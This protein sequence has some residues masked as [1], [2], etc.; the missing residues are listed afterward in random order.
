MSSQKTPLSASKRAV[1]IKISILHTSDRDNFPYTSVE[2]RWSF[3]MNLLP[4]TNI[5]EL[6]I[7]ATSQVQRTF[8][9]IQEAARLEARDRDGHVFHGMET[10]AEEIL[11]GETIYLVEG[12]GEG[13]GRGKGKERGRLLSLR[14]GAEQAYRTPST[15]SRSSSTSR[16]KAQSQP[17]MTPSQRSR[18][19]AKAGLPPGYEPARVRRSSTGAIGRTNSPSPESSHVAPAAALKGEV[20]NRRDDASNA[21]DGEPAI[22]KQETSIAQSQKRSPSPHTSPHLQDSQKLIPD[23]QNN[24][25]PR[26][27]LQSHSGSRVKLASETKLRLG[28]SELRPTQPRSAPPRLNTLDPGNIHNMPTPPTKVL[29]SRPDPYDISSVLSDNEN[30]S[31]TR[32]SSIMSSSVRKLG[33]AYKRRIPASQPPMRQLQLTANSPS[34]TSKSATADRYDATRNMGFQHLT[35][36]DKKT[37]T[38]F[39]VEASSPA[40]ALPSSPTNNVAAAIAKGRSKIQRRSIPECVVISDSEDDIDEELFRNPPAMP[41]SIPSVEASLPWSQ[42]PLW[43]TQDKVLGVRPVAHRASMPSAGGRITQKKVVGKE[44]VVDSTADVRRLV[45][46]V[47]GTLTATSVNSN[48]RS[49]AL[50]SSAISSFGQPVTVIDSLSS[51]N[52]SDGVD[53]CAPIIKAEQ[54]EDDVWKDLPDAIMSDSP[55]HQDGGDKG[56]YPEV[57]QLSSDSD[58]SIDPAWLDDYDVDLPISELP[59]I[60]APPVINEP[61]LPDPDPQDIELP[62]PVVPLQ[63]LNSLV[64]DPVEPSVNQTPPSAQPDKRKR[65]LVGDSDSENEREKKRVKKAEKRR[66]R[67]A[68]RRAKHEELLARMEEERKKQALEQAHLRALELEIIVSSP[69]NAKEP[70]TDDAEVDD[71]SGLDLSILDDDKYVED[72]GA[73]LDEDDDNESW[74]RMKSEDGPFSF[75]QKQVSSSSES[76]R[77]SPKLSVGAADPDS[78]ASED[79]HDQQEQQQDSNAVKT[80]K[81]QYYREPFDDWAALEATLG[82]GGFGYSP[83]EVHNRIHLATVHRCL[84]FP[85]EPSA[86]KYEAEEEEID[87]EIPFVDPS[88]DQD[89]QSTRLTQPVVKVKRRNRKR[90]KKSIASPSKNPPQFPNHDQSS[91]RSIRSGAPSPKD[92]PPAPE[93]ASNKGRKEGK[94]G[95]P[96]KTKPRSRRERERNRARLQRKQRAEHNFSKFRGSVKSRRKSH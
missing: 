74:S 52:M 34:R 49:K 95:K 32:P 17:R 39:R 79:A 89:A 86:I 5:K 6:C 68:L 31:P 4:M 16:K 43:A 70:R 58:S 92:T 81:N 69:T 50:P 75:D 46:A 30:H 42:P 66:A 76:K 96:S 87:E 24:N 91:P 2:P 72:V 63:E 25:S 84:Q 83:L 23:S 80:A 3:T 94:K 88:G 37:A 64:T 38:P 82:T 71:D 56:K 85:N 14:S 22:P 26:S 53:K 20:L 67:K 59:V 35:T 54:S 13:A 28:A 29:T 36:P 45:D 90:G 41:A 77:D 93:T 40:I 73:P 55:V 15:S 61:L 48:L 51:E 11:N 47:K 57:I 78:P 27:P 7:H 62:A 8:N 12:A 10:I 33:S 65:P 19:M 21:M 60:D 1:P 44:D 9:A 18:A